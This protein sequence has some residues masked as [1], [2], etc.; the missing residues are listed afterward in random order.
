MAIKVQSIA[1]QKSVEPVMEELFAS[2][3]T[4]AEGLLGDCSALTA[5]GEV[6]VLSKESWIKVCH[7]VNIELPWLAHGANLFIKGFEFLP[8][9]IG[10]T[11]RIGEAL[12]EIDRAIEHLPALAQQAPALH[13]GLQLGWRGGVICR[14]MRS[15]SIQTGDDVF[16]G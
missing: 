1:R 5:G 6:S 12:L 3:I 8:T 7:E 10:R 9:D 13:E 15:G 11:I 4:L 14:V 16:I 2:D